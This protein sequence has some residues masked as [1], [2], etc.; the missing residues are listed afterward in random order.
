MRI[1]RFEDDGIV[2][3]VF[4]FNDANWSFDPIV[5][6]A[7]DDFNVI[8]WDA[9]LD[10]V[11][12]S[13]QN[14]DDFQEEFINRLVMTVSDD[15]STILDESFNGY[16]LNV[17]ETADSG[18]LNG[19][20]QDIRTGQY[21]GEAGGTRTITVVATTNNLN[22]M[23]YDTEYS[24]GPGGFTGVSVTNFTT[25]RFDQ[26]ERSYTIT[27]RIHPTADINNNIDSETATTNDAA[28]GAFSSA[29]ITNSNGTIA[30]FIGAEIYHDTQYSGTTTA[31]FT[32]PMD[33]VP[34]MNDTE[35]MLVDDDDWS[36]NPAIRYRTWVFVGDTEAFAESDLGTLDDDG[37]ALDST[38]DNDSGTGN[39]TGRSYQFDNSA[40]AGSVLGFIVAPSSIDIDTRFTDPDS[41]DAAIAGITITP[42]MLGHADHQ[43]QYYVYTFTLTAG[44]ILNVDVS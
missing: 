42:V 4:V 32:R 8:P 24:W 23:T 39:W 35:R 18:D 21:M 29:G 2:F 41:L 43:V 36:F 28:S 1:R 11:T 3:A 22:T 10:E 30:N 20:T 31:T 40:G 14:N 17:S 33:L 16:A 9:R 6:N 34:N 25:L 15:S 12:F 44:A 7:D 37:Y 19:A 38:R 27:S 13:T 5:S 26:I